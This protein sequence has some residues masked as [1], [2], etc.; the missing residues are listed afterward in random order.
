L[1]KPGGRVVLKKLPPRLLDG[2][3]EEDQ[4]AISAIVGV[5]IR[6]S[7][8]ED[9]GSLKLEFVEDDGTIHMIYVD[10]Q[11][12]RAAKSGRRKVMKRGR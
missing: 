3:P 4:K 12:V 9:D 7:G 1:P 11:F 2:L 5:P 6:F 8:F 10:R